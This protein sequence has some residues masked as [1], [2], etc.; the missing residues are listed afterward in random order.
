MRPLFKWMNKIFPM[1]WMVGLALSIDNMMMR[2]KG[3]HADKL[4]VTY[5][6]E[7]DGFQCD[8]LCD[9]GYCYQFYFRND[10]AP[11]QFLQQCCD[12]F[13]LVSWR[14]LIA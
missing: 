7:G 11:A 12:L 5:K 3:K 9:D 6:N 4:R 8:A 13:I 2:F 10:P 14:F 1:V